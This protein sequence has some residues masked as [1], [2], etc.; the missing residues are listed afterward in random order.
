[1]CIYIYIY[2]YIYYA[3]YQGAAEAHVQTRTLR[4]YTLFA[5]FCRFRI[6]CFDQCFLCSRWLAA[7]ACAP[8]HVHL[9]GSR[10][11]AS[12]LERPRGKGKA[13]GK[14]K[15]KVVDEE[16]PPLRRRP[17]LTVTRLRTAF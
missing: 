16:P 17:P 1:M 3:E 7:T 11:V 12:E 10:R 5:T 8:L 9:C 6:G 13:K 4:L 2:I 15:G 14:G